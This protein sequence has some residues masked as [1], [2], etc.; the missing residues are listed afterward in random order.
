MA[1]VIDFPKPADP[2]AARWKATL[3]YRDGLMST[4][5]REVFFEEIADLHDI[6]EDS[7]NWNCLVACIVT[8]NRV[9]HPGLTIEGSLTL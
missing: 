7:P 6:V 1:D 3:L 8:L 5:P 9:H 4:S 2:K